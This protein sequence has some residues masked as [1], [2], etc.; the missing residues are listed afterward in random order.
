MR[1]P[2]IWTVDAIR[3]HSVAEE[4]PATALTPAYWRPCRPMA[5]NAFSWWWR[6]KLAWM[7]FTGQCDC[8]RWY[9]E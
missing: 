3:N 7:V 8:L 5:H 9:N 2:D 4:V 6:F 1:Q